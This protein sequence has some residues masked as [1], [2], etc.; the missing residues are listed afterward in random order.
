MRILHVPPN[1]ELTRN[2]SAANDGLEVIERGHNMF[3]NLYYILIR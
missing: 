1:Q 2:P 3:G